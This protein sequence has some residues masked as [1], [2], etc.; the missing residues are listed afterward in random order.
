MSVTARWG[1]ENLRKVRLKKDSPAIRIRAERTKR[2]R[3][4]ENHKE[5]GVNGMGRERIKPNEMCR[6]SA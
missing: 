4:K 3:G 5:T 1:S 2:I 6:R